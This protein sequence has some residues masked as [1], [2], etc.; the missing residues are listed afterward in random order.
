MDHDSSTFCSPDPQM[1][2]QWV[3]RAEVA[4]RLKLPVSTLN[5]WASK[6]LGPPYTIFGRH[7]R[8]RLADVIVWENEQI[9]A[10]IRRGGGA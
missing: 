10:T 5:G 2:Y 6:G 4:E 7:A 1:T 3:T 8:Y 9:S